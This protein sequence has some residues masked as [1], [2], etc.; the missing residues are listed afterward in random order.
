MLRGTVGAHVGEDP[1]V[2]ERAAVRGAQ[3]STRA[4]RRRVPGRPFQPGQS[5]NPGGQPKG[6]V[7][8]IRQ[9]TKDRRELVALMLKVAN[10]ARAAGAVRSR[11]ATRATPAGAPR[12]RRPTACGLLWADALDDPKIRK[13]HVQV[14]RGLLTDPKTALAANET[15]GRY[16]RELGPVDA[17]APTLVV[18][19]HTNVDPHRL[20]GGETPPVPSPRPRKT[21]SRRQPL[22]RERHV[23]LRVVREDGISH[24]LGSHSRPTRGAYWPPL[25]VV[26]IGPSSGWW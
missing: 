10:R 21:G 14:L 3:S 1:G 25:R 16:N 26:V 9:Q 17:V 5:G 24:R 18:N 19:V 12:A 2:I 22:A 7:R 15:A 20:R 6:L 11:A 13:R 4:A 8:S 23:P